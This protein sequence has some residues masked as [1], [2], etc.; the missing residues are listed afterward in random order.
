MYPNLLS[1][2]KV[3]EAESLCWQLQRLAWWQAAKLLLARRL[4]GN[5]LKIL[6]LMPGGL[7][8]LASVSSAAFFAS[9]GR[10]TLT[11][12]SR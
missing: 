11:Y 1:R 9:P 10:W 8:E 7:I 4:S 2:W 3:Q 6:N 5:V 12:W